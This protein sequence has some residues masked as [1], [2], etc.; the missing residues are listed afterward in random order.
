M[1]NRTV[2]STINTLEQRLE[3]LLEASALL[4]ESLDYESRLRRLAEISVPKI[5][6][7]CAVDILGS[8]GR[9]NRLAVV[10][11]DPAKIEL[12][13]EIERRYPAPPDDTRGVYKVVKTGEPDFYE[14]IPES[15]LIASAKDEEHLELLRDLGL[16]SAM[17]VPLASHGTAMGAVTL[18]LAESGRRYTRDDL[19]LAQALAGRAAMYIENA[20]LFTD[21]EAAVGRRTMELEAANAELEAFSYSVSHDLRAPLRHIS[22]FV[23]LLRKNS[24]ASLDEKSSHYLDTIDDAAKRMGNL[25]DDLLSFSRI[26][27]A[28]L[29]LI[30]TDL[31][32]IVEKILTETAQEYPQRSVHW[33]VAELPVVHCDGA[34]IA[35]VFRNLIDN[36]VKFT[37]GRAPAEIEIGYRRDGAA[38][39]FFVKDN[40]AG[41]DSKYAGNL[42]QVFQRMHSHAEFEGTGIGLA[43][44]RRIVER[45]GGEVKADGAVGKGATITFSLPAKSPKEAR[46]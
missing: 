25:I 16:R 32:S 10:H 22:G 31:S 26:G 43:N 29:R 44:V 14:E 33:S 38:H 6:D 46:A 41:F 4:S 42:F 35:Q 15:I 18:V 2:R 37:A 8:D 24:G 34:L 30:P 1:G 45:H 36:A 27:R 12:V 23:Q 39:V 20:R 3:F 17:V 7:W 21:L 5:A 11:S 40:G 13:F 9:T 28:E 19:E